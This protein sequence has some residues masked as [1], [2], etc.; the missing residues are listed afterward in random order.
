MPR[1]QTAAVL[2]PEHDPR[3]GRGRQGDWT[4]VSADSSCVVHLLLA[5]RAYDRCVALTPPN[6]T[7]RVEG[8]H[9][10]PTSLSLRKQR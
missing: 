6:A 5:R 7:E 9:A 10:R 1:M 2:R 4:E 8:M 3:G